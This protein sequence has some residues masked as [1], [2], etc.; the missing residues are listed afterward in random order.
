ML[1]VIDGARGY[2][3]LNAA[4]QV[5]VMHPAAGYF[6]EKKSNTLC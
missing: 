5:I 3:R 2:H 6:S 1:R 4:A